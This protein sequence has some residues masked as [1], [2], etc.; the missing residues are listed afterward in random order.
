MFK[1]IK[2]RILAITILMLAVLMAAFAC[3]GIVFRMKTKQLML[4]NYSFSINKFAYELNEKIIDF[5]NNSEDLSLIGY[6]FY[7]TDRS[8][9][10]TKEAIKAIFENYKHSLGG[11]IWFEPYV[12]NPNEKRHCYYI[13]RGKDNV[14]RF[15]E[16]FGSEEY[17]YH[18]QNWYKEIKSQVTKD[19][20]VAWSLPY[21]EDIGS[22]TFMITIGSGIYD[23]NSNLIGISTVDWKLGNVLN[24]LTQMKPI[25]HGFQM[26]EQRSQI[27]DSFAMLGNLDRN[28]IIAS[29]DPY[30]DNEKIIGEK[31]ESLPWYNKHLYEQTYITYQGK[32]YVPFVKNLRDGL[33]MIMCIP[34]VEMFPEVNR[35]ALNM[36]I[37]LCLI[38]IL[39]PGLLY[40]S[41]NRN[42]INPITELMKIAHKVSKGEDIEIKLEKPEEMAKL[43]STFD[44]MTKN[45]KT[46]TIEKEK[47]NSELS[48]AKSIQESSL[49][50]VFPPFPDNKEFSIY[51]SMEAAKEVGGDFYDFYFR[52]KNNLMFLIA[53]VSGKGIPA[54]MFMMTGKTLINN[55][56]QINYEPKELI[57]E[58]NN[59]ICASNKER[60]F[61]TM[62]AG[63]VDITTGKLTL[64]NC[65]HNQ[66]LIK[67]FN[68]KYE[69]LTL[70]PNMVLGIFEN[71]EFNTYET[72]LNIG[73]I[74][75]TYTDGITEAMNPDEELFGERRLIESLNKH[76]DITDV[77]ELSDAIKNDIK[78]FTQN[79]EQSDDITMLIFKY[80]NV[81][82][83]RDF[84]SEAKIE[85]Y[86][87]FYNWLHSVCEE[88][89]LNDEISNAI[90][91]CGEEIFANIVF[92]AYP[93]TKGNIEAN[94]SR[95]GNEVSLRF[96]DS[97][98]EYN[99]LEKPD[100]DINLPPEERPLGGLGIFMVKQMAKDVTYE[101]KDNKNILTIIFGI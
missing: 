43:A 39:I 6:L 71:E 65:G 44:R 55:L 57:K 63:I 22:T 13:Y 61:I 41:L 19:N 35:F 93:D 74:I 72:K 84:K 5:E 56:S 67:R 17:D 28:Y 54:A 62:L 1:T 59:K 88:W 98:I 78:E 53:D 10:L 37:I 33:Q 92:Y 16:S 66:A 30:I 45:I 68:G 42:I 36:L 64:I 49:P 101:R 24:D 97:G 60:L 3:Y 32:K 47:I 76:Q 51:A 82:D 25:E 83:K 52:D 69:Y 2:S 8:Q 79:A 11:G 70:N 12:I 7:Q 96:E 29:N 73:D 99:P 50:N 38:G 85:N 94:I 26:Y 46:I 75:F 4:Q 95:E 15:D 21:Y 20:N 14:L 100:P 31:L 23:S 89:K 81:N 90:D 9:G 91:M 18:N 77:K 48:V 87:L 80:E 40:L 86:K 34:K 58:I 27:K